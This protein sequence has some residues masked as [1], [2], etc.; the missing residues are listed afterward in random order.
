[1]VNVRARGPGSSSGKGECGS[2]GVRAGGWDSAAWDG[3]RD[4][5]L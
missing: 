5:T 1:M 2:E 4:G 3:S